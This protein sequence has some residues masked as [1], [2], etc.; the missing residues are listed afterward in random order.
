MAN[1]SS[2]IFLDLLNE[3][4]TL[5]LSL[6]TLI[7]VYFIYHSFKL[8]QK[9]YEI[10]NR[11]YLAISKDTSLP[12]V[13]GGTKFIFEIKNSGKT[14]AQLLSH[15]I[16]FLKCEDP[17]EKF[18]NP[19]NQQTFNQ[20]PILL[21]GQTT[22]FSIDSPSDK[23]VGLEIKIKYNGIVFRKVFGTKILFK[24]EKRMVYPIDSSVF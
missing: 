19:H 21:S 10:R 8:S 13:G 16:V 17:G 14:P 4:S 22:T 15:E 1:T 9:D 2:L 3:Y 12:L 6:I 18:S 5:I 11:P 24:L 23:K 20:K 7:Y